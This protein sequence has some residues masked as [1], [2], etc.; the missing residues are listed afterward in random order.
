MCNLA[1]K[2]N[3]QTKKK[4]HTHTTTPK[5][6]LFLSKLQKIPEG[7]EKYELQNWH[8]ISKCRQGKFAI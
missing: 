8:V 4:T 5:L 2:Q 6:S 7:S 1:K 3:K